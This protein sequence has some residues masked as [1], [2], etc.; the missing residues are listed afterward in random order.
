MGNKETASQARKEYAN[1]ANTISKYEPLSMC[2]SEE[3]YDVCKKL[4]SENV[5]V[6]SI[7]T[8][9]C[10]MRDTG[11][12]FVINENTKQVAG[13]DW[14]FNGY[15][16]KFPHD[17]DKII[18]RNIIAMQ[19]FKRFASP[20]ILEGGSIHTDGEGTLL[21]TEECLLKRNPSLT[22]EDI[23]VQLQLSLGISKVIWIPKGVKYDVDTDG[24]VD[25][26]CCFARPGEVI[27][28]YPSSADHFQRNRSEKAKQILEQTRDARGRS[29][30]VHL[31]VHPNAILVE[32]SEVVPGL[33]EEGQYLAASY[34]NFYM[35]N[36]AIIAP[37][38]CNGE[39][40][41]KVAVDQLKGI[42]PEREVVGVPSALLLR[43]GGNIHCVTQQQPVIKS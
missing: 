5:N 22:K 19:G 34:I 25:N 39:G 3:D 21:T 17:N 1:I 26:M 37:Q 36:G 30:K 31:L 11:P 7:P 6:I 4:L 35:A 40:T 14:I 24:H 41:D 2:C 8:D 20:L 16:N 13:V 42:F 10:W 15:S 23:E 33:R 29:L 28:T 27:L 12:T 32:K 18:A 38:F 43:G 9:D